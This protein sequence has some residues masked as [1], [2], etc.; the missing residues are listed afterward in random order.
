MW[1]R[2]PKALGATDSYLGTKGKVSFKNNNS[3]ADNEKTKLEN[4]VGGGTKKMGFNIFF[5]AN[6]L[7]LL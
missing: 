2:K 3:K 7:S 5:R 6:G 4:E 1:I